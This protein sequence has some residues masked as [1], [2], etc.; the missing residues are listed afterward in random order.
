MGVE[1]FVCGCVG[2]GWGDGDEAGVSGVG[3]C[4]FVCV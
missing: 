3:V 1:E 2:S 4:V